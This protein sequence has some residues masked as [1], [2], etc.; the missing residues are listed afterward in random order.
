[1]PTLVPPPMTIAIPNPKPV[2]TPILVPTPPAM[3]HLI[4]HNFLMLTPTQEDALVIASLNN[5]L[6]Y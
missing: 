3:H 2:P 6:C 4:L 5:L 1:M